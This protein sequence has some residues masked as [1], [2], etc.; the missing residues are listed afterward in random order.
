[1]S[2]HPTRHEINETDED[3]AW[4]IFH[5]VTNAQVGLTHDVTITPSSV[6]LRIAILARFVVSFRFVFFQNNKRRKSLAYL[7][8]RSVV[9]VVS[10]D[11]E[12]G[13]VKW[14]VLRHGHL[15]ASLAFKPRPVVIDVG[16]VDVHVH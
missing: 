9:V 4:C 8:V 3:W 2:I 1:M 10:M 15:V 14:Q 11:G 12:Y 16:D 13:G 5:N 6:P 7:S